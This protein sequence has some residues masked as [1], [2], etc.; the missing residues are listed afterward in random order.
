[1]EVGRF[2]SWEVWKLGGLEVGRFGSWE[3]WKLGGLEVVSSEW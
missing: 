3:V 2:G 1:L